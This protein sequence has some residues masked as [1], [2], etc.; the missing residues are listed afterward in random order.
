MTRLTVGLASAVTFGALSALAGARALRVDAY[1]GLSLLALSLF[2][3][4]LLLPVRSREPTR[5]RPSAP[6]ETPPRSAPRRRDKSPHQR[7]LRRA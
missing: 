2:G 6:D 1:L 5:A 7:S 3:A 4:A